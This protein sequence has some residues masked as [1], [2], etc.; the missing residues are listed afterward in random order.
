MRRVLLPP[1]GRFTHF[2]IQDLGKVALV[3]KTVG[4]GLISTDHGQSF[5]RNS[6][7]PHM[8]YLISQIENSLLASPI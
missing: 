3:E 2:L 8:P 1:G 6:M 7:I 4:Q 5:T